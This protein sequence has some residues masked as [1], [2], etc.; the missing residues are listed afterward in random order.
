MVVCSH[1]NSVWS[2]SWARGARDVNAKG[3][4]EDSTLCSEGLTITITKIRQVVA[5][6]TRKG[7]WNHGFFVVVSASF[8]SYF[9]DNL[10]KSKLQDY[11][12]T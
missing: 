1:I 7:Q 5:A 2:Q 3:G 12:G 11:L 8:R 9:S 6:V 10:M 4:F